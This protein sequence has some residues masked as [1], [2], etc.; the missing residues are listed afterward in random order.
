MVTD[1][2]EVVKI[3]R[4]PAYPSRGFPQRQLVQEQ[5]QKSDLGT[6]H[7]AELDVSSS[8]GMHLRV[9]SSVLWYNPQ[10]RLCCLQFYT[11]AF[12]CVCSSVQF[13]HV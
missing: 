1:S 7:S 10:S 13:H 2:Q 9:C 8:T 5:R 6:T 4:G 12:V 11:H 3:Q